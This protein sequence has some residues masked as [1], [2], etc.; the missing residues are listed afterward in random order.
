MVFF[1]AVFHSA[2]L[3]C[4]LLLQILHIHCVLLFRSCVR[5]H[6]LSLLSPRHVE[7]AHG[8]ALR[9]AMLGPLFLERCG[10]CISFADAAVQLGMA[11][12]DLGDVDTALL[13]LAR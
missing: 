7:H 5:L 3:L 12:A 2:H 6:K 9:L 10:R 4:P 13:A 8:D 11:H 1:D